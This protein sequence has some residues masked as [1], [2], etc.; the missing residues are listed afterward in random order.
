MG[1]ESSSTVVSRRLCRWCVPSDG[2]AQAEGAGYLATAALDTVTHCHI[3]RVLCCT[4][5]ILWQEKVALNRKAVP[6]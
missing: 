3:Q 5:M 4:Y 6:D 1:P 2:P